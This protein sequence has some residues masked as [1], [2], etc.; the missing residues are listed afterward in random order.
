MKYSYQN[1]GRVVVFTLS[2]DFTI[3]DA[4]QMHRSALERI[5][6]GTRD[7][8][9]DCEHLEY[10]DSAALETLLRVREHTAEKGG[11]VRLVRVDDT[12]RKILEMTRLDGM[13]QSAESVE[14]AVRSLR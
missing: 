10:L 8:V 13:F 5:E 3:D 9:V 4:D 7:V 14:D 2:G 1:F 6:A 12:V 11:S